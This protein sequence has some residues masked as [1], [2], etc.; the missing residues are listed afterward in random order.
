MSQPFVGQ[1]GVFGFNFPPKNWA[2]CAGQQM[3]IAQNQALFALL[4]TT[5]GGNGVT[6]FG[7]P[8]LRGRVAVGTGPSLS[9]G[10]TYT[11]G[12]IGGEPSHTLITNEIPQHTHFLQANSTTDASANASAGAAN[13]VLG[14]SQQKA[15]QG[16]TSQPLY[17]Y[18]SPSAN[19][20]PLAPN[21]LA[22]AGGSQ[23]HENR[24]PYMGT[25]I[26]IALF[27]IF[28]SRN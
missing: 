27:G 15:P 19:L 1:L 24:Q 7:L 25:N 4:G 23:P 10:G 12:Q 16:G 21:A 14:K 11:L 22:N 9:G 2:L 17:P 18:T 26:C 3:S 5:Y 13:T 8:D 20:T 6:T 28:P